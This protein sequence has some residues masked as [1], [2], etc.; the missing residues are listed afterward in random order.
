[1]GP[2]RGLVVRVSGVS[3]K[4]VQD[5]RLLK[6]DAQL[7]YDI[8][9]SLVGNLNLS[10]SEAVRLGQLILKIDLRKP[11]NTPESDRQDIQTLLRQAVSDR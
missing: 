11:Q 2:P 8:D 1:M 7:L 9:Q 6:A 5:E 3:R 10:R 4:L